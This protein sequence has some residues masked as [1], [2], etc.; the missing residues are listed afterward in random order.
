MRSRSTLRAL[1]LLLPCA[2]CS[3][4]PAAERPP[5]VVRDLQA[6][7][8]FAPGALR[9]I[10]VP[11]SAADLTVLHLHVE[12]APVAERFERGHRILLLPADC[13]SACVRCRVQHWEPEVDAAPSRVLFPGACAVRNEPVRQD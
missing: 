4:F 9:A 13:A 3:V 1:G 11:A 6:E 2:A 10:E 5:S 7:F 12:P 8:N